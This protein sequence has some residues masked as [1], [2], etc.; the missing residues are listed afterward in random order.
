MA[1][2]SAS[3]SRVT[4]RLAEVLKIASQ[5]AGALT[6]AH[7]AGIVHRD[8]KP[9]NIM[10]DDERRV[11]VLD[12]GIAKLAGHEPTEGRRDADGRAYSGG[13]DHRQRVVHGHGVGTRARAAVSPTTI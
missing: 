8:P 12:F 10:M 11:K 9:A 1:S 7:A 5:V 2:F 3:G 6:A 4:M 13:G